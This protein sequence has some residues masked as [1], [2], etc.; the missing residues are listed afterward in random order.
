MN[1]G[2]SGFNLLQ[3]TYNEEKTFIDKRS[4]AGIKVKKF[5]HLLKIAG[6]FSSLAKC[7]FFDQLA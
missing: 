3:V 7:V 2:A 4:P 5:I 6:D 1:S